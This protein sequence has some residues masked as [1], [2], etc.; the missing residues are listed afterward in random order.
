[1]FGERLNIT[2]KNK[3]IT[4]QQMA[5]FLNIG[6]HSY[7]KYESNGR[8]P[9][10]DVLVKIADRLDAS[11]DYLLGRDAYLESHVIHVDEC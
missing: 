7:R 3:G 11:I 2:R 10:F 6:L 8:Q 5:D 1:M 9:S 4:A